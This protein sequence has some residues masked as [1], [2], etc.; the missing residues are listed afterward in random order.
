MKIYLIHKNLGFKFKIW[1]LLVIKTLFYKYLLI[2]KPIKTDKI[3]IKT[4]D[5]T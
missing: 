1:Y 5:K 2:F 4:L 3:P